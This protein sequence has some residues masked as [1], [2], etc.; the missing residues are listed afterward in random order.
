[1]NSNKMMF[2]VKTGDTQTYKWPD[3]KILNTAQT[4]TLK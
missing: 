4:Y 3:E 1:M 2:E